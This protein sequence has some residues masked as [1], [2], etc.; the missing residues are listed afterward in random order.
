VFL[1][2][3]PK[4][5]ML[6]EPNLGK[7]NHPCHLCLLLVICLSSPSLSSLALFFVDIAL[8]C[9]WLNSHI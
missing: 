8:C 9:F 3:G 7:T 6:H 4:T 2:L 5:G 1:T